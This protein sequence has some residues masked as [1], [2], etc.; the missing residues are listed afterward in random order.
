VFLKRG[1]FDPITKLNLDMIDRAQAAFRA[2]FGEVAEGSIEILEITMHNLLA[3]GCDVPDSEFLGRADILQA[4]GKNVLISRYPQFHRISSYLARHTQKPI[5]IVLGLPL[6][7]ELFNERWCTDLEGGLLES[8]GR[9]FKNQ[10][11]VYVYPM[12]DPVTGRLVGARDATVTPEQK[13]LLRYLIDTQNVRPLEVPSQ[14][15]LF[16]TSAAVRNMI[17]QGIPGWE[18]LVPDVVLQQGPWKTLAA[19]ASAITQPL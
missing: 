1:S 16:H 3:S 7:Q 4:L 9:L 6:F 10:V 19:G 14:E 8:F 17:Q 15:F 11:H 2:D 13:H 18:S 5:A 12:G